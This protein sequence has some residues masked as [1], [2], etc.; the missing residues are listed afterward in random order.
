MN[1]GGLRDEIKDRKSSMDRFECVYT[2]EILAFA[3][4]RR[5]VCVVVTLSVLNDAVLERRSCVDGVYG[6]VMTA[7]QPSR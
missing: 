7:L 3:R 6:T 1:P 5:A 2:R 4:L